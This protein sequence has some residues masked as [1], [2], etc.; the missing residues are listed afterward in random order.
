[1]Y[2]IVEFKGHQYRVEKDQVLKVPYLGNLDVGSE[3]KLNNVLLIGGDNSTV[4]GKPNID[5]ASV[6][7]EVLAHVKAKKIIVF[8]KKRRKG[9]VKKQG[10]R[11]KFTEIKIKEIIQ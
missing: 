4:L 6:S 10:H 7:A 9:Y 1:M 2:A 5:S 8:K 11:Q 3:V